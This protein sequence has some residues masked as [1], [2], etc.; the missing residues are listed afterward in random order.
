MRQVNIRVLRATLST[1][2]QDLPF[3]ITRNGRIIGVVC[4]QEDKNKDVEPKVK[5]SSACNNT[6]KT[7]SHTGGRPKIDPFYNVFFN[8]YY[9]AK[10]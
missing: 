3:E 8:P 4:T 5:K 6:E 2:L 10:I 7:T 1:Q 9:K